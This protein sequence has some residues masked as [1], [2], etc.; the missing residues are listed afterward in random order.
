MPQY[1]RYIKH[2][3]KIMGIVWRSCWHGNAQTAVVVFSTP[4]ID[5]SAVQTCF[6]HALVAGGGNMCCIISQGQPCK[7]FALY[8]YIPLIGS[9]GVL[10]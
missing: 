5:G 1:R 9:L 2:Q 8:I 10:F 4:T 6:P 3:Q 7:K